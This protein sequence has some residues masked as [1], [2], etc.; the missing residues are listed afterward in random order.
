MRADMTRVATLSDRAILI[1]CAVRVD[2]VRAV[3]LLVRLAVVAG[4]V[5]LDLGAYTDAVADFDGRD[6]FADLDG[7]ADDLVADAEWQ[8]DIFAPAAGD[9]VDVGGADS[10]GVN[11]DVDVAV[12]EGLELELSASDCQCDFLWRS[13]R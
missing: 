10:A 7:L 2:R 13:A 9:G 5:G 6:I 11:G 12:F 4:Q 8:R 3:V 1:R